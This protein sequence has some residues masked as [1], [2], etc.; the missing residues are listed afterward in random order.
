[1]G[2]YLEGNAVFGARVYNTRVLARPLYNEFTL[3]RK[4]A[5]YGLAV[6]ITAVFR[7]HCGKNTQFNV[8]GLAAKYLKNIFVL[9]FL[10]TMVG[11]YFLGQF[12]RIIIHAFSL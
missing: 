5:Q 9:A 2:F 1:M 6:L 10:K 11:Y 12:N 8:R 3:A 7:P 4:T